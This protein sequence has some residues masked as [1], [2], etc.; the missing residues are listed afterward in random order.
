M[1]GWRRGPPGQ[2]AHRR[3]RAPR[4]DRR[5]A[6]PSSAGRLRLR[7][8]PASRRANLRRAVAD[9]AGQDP[10]ATL[11]DFSTYVFNDAQRTWERTFGGTGRPTSARRSSSTRR[12]GH[13]LKRRDRRGRPVLRPADY[14]YLDPLL[15]R[16]HGAQARR[17]RRLR[18]GL[19]DRARG[20]HHC[21]NSSAPATGDHLRRP[22]RQGQR[23]SVRWSSRP[24]VT[25]AGPQ[26]IRGRSTR[27]T[28]RKRHGSRPSVTAASSAGRSGD[29]PRFVHPRRPSNGVAGST[30][31]ARRAH[32]AT[33]SR[34]TRRLS[35]RRLDW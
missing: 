5:A 9:P 27:A 34:S 8:R 23:A 3:A 29:E 7:D 35:T 1:R 2:P 15:L 32:D 17:P 33:R 4:R 25:P 19:R 22:A 30:A 18:L 31:G 20:G 16:R 6:P 11:K 24:T 13:G 21:S 12:G 28:S 14:V 10:N 26:R